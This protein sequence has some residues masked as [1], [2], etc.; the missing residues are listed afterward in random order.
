MIFPKQGNVLEKFFPKSFSVSGADNFQGIESG[1]S[2]CGRRRGGVDEGAGAI[3]EELYPIAAGG[4]ISA[5]EAES[6]AERSHL[7]M[8]VF[9]NAQLLRQAHAGG[10]EDTNR[11]G[12]IKKKLG[13]LSLADAENFTQW[14]EI[15]VHGENGFRDDEEA[16]ARM[17]PP[18]CG[19]KFCEPFSIVVGKDAERGLGHAC[20]IDE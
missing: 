1:V 2:E 6:L 13:T 9:L 17:F 4:E 10:A 5:G 16:S 12:F 20:G 3:D 7:K 14:A 19:E 8:D 15:A 18:Q 11:M